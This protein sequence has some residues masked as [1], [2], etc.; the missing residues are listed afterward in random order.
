MDTSSTGRFEEGVGKAILYLHGGAYVTGSIQTHRYMH[1]RL[2]TTTK[3]PVFAIEYRLAPEFKYPTQLYDAY[4]AYTYLRQTL[5]YSSSNIVVAGDSAGGN[6]A[7]ALWQLVR[8]Q[9]DSLRALILMSPRV[10]ISY[11]RDSW[12]TNAEIDYL[13]PEHIRSIQSSVFMLLGP[14]DLAEFKAESVVSYVNE[15]GSDPFLAPI[16]A[17]L[18]ELPPTLIQASKLE[19]MYSDICEFTARATLAIEQR[20]ENR[21]RGSVELQVFPDGVHVFQLVSSGMR[22]VEEFWYNIGV[23]HGTKV[24]DDRGFVTANGSRLIRN[25]STYHVSGANYWQA[26]N[27]GMADGPSSNRPR[28]LRDLET[29]ASY[30]IN[31]VRIMAASEG[32][33]FGT[34]PDRTY[35]VLMDSPGIYNE[36]VF[37]GLDWVLAQLPRYNMTATV[38]LANYW[39]W[40]GGIP[41]YV[42]WAT[43]TE[44]PYPSQWDPLKQIFEGGD[45]NTFL[46]YANRFYADE[47]IYPVVQ[48][49]YKAHV[50]T[51]LERVN[52]VTGIRYKDDPAIMAWELMNEPQI[53]DNVDD[54]AGER[55]LFRWIDDSAKYI[56]SIDTHHLVTTGAESKNGARWFDVMH[57]SEHIT[58]ASCHFWPLNWGYYNSTDPTNAS[59]DYSIT[60]MRDFVRSNSAWAHELRLPA[61]LFEYG[62]MRDNWGKYSGVGAYSPDAPVSHRNR[63]YRA[64]V[65]CVRE[66]SAST[67]RGAMAGSAFWAYSGLGRPPRAPTT[68]LTWTGDPPHEPPG[69]NSVYDKDVET[70]DIIRLNSHTTI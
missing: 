63:F 16:N 54:D 25:G 46:A 33:Q 7:L 21:G 56:R 55:L 69:W 18:S 32:S 12:R 20:G 45:Y 47:S 2:S 28:V 13:Q 3:L 59:V 43:D 4:C 58:L 29:L 1:L 50:R 52:T 24:Y 35:P 22:G 14:H 51:V 39:T 17:N 53:I 61:V 19:T 67:G 65:D 68:A 6:L 42:G 57:R 66:F 38:T 23:F 40:S 62:M 15:L 27:L 41:Q 8:A 26:M 5:G 49:W 10:D 34:A 64:V 44:I 30:G 70:L 48:G 11:T 60:K 31:M 9:G 36:A 37:E